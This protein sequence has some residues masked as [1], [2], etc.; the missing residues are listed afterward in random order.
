MV[1]KVLIHILTKT[2]IKNVNFLPFEYLPFFDGI[3]HIFIRHIQFLWLRYRNFVVQETN[4]QNHP[5]LGLVINII[6]QI[7]EGDV[8]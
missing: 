6:D 7:D 4:D 1:N 8:T 2:P 5:G 3:T